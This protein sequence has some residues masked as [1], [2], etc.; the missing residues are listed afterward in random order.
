MLT[1]YSHTALDTFHT[2]PRKFKFQYIEKVDIPKRV[3][4]D[5]YMG[6][7]VHRVLARLYQLGADGIVYPVDDMLSFYEQQW[8]KVDLELLTLTDEFHTVDDYIRMGREMLKTHYEHYQPFNQG[9][10][11]GSELNMVFTLP[12]TSFKVK[13]V[14]DRLWKRDDGVVEICDYK[15]GRSLARPHDQRFFYQMGL[16]QL[17][18]RQQYPQF[19]T[20]EL[21]QYFLRLNEVVSYRM[22]PDELDQLT[23]E[24]RATILET[25]DAERLDN[26]PAQ[27]GRWCHYCGYFDLC[28]AKRHKLML[29]KKD[30]E[31][32]VA[33]KQEVPKQAYDLATRYLKTHQ[34]AR[35]VKAELA[36]LKEEL[37][38]LAKEHEL[39][40]LEGE[41][42]KVTVRIDRKEK[43]VGKSENPGAYA[44][45]S[46]LARTWRLD[47]YFDLNTNM[48]M[49][50]I[51]QKK[52]L[53]PEQLEQLKRYVVE[54]EESRVTV[55]LHQDI[56]DDEA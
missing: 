10:L 40:T 17:A 30:E 54:K 11:L 28:P 43:F 3:T 36:A 34:Q 47:D 35:E 48:L 29:T 20:I 6:N 24:I 19:E 18:I 33:D 1:T 16:Y 4:A 8:E 13:A 52:R 12:K 7:A 44:E 15:T 14:I 49:K 9:T 39:T 26:F 25:I 45:L 51:Y 23:E 2:C 22:R 37:I 5:T 55:K 27:E 53:E 21:A 56:D 38:R 32:P 50:E 31:A 42:G 46:H 41:T